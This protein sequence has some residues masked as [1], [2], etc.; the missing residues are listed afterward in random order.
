[1]R[2]PKLLLTALA[3]VFIFTALLSPAAVFARAE[4]ESSE[5]GLNFKITFTRGYTF[6]NP[7]TGAEADHLFTG[8]TPEPVTVNRGGSFVFPENTIKFYD[9]VF[10]CWKYS[11]KDKDGNTVTEKYSPG[12]I[13]ENV[14]GDM[15]VGAVWKRPVP[16]KLVINGFITFNKG[17][18]Y[19]EGE[20]IVPYR[21][22]C[23]KAIKLPDCPY[24]KDGYD[25]AGWVD[26]DGVLC[27]AGADYTV[28][29]AN[30][31]LTAVWNKNGESILTH[32]VTYSGGEGNV[33]GKG[34]AQFEMYKK[35]SFKVA[36]NTFVKEGYTF[37]YW[38]DASGAAR[39]PGDVLEVPQS[40][41]SQ[42]MLTAVWQQIT[43]YC[44]IIFA[45]S[46]DGAITPSGNAKVAKGGSYSFGLSPASGYRIKTVKVNGVDKP[47][48]SSYIIENI[49][50]NIAV[51]VVFE[52]IPRHAVIITCGEGGEAYADMNVAY[53]EEGGSVT[54]HIIPDEGYTVEAVYINGEAAVPSGGMLAINN[55]TEDI[56]VNVEFKSDENPRSNAFSAHDNSSEL[57]INPPTSVKYIYILAAFVALMTL[58]FIVFKI[59]R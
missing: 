58:G 43:E 39:Y 36:E 29:K 19:A 1:M 10:V 4:N 54:V 42:T 31:V 53:I 5:D 13:Y 50:E 45:V 11:Y 24:T 38:K 2:R 52:E 40:G 7:L 37:L 48:Q 34:P 33:T 3:C 9:Y 23:G 26:G 16:I 46:G 27:R 56:N 51:N 32:T 17:D 22:T 47:V 35:T 25:F 57:E 49:T 8:K 55:I 18:E 14:T 59:K 44:D 6:I 15:T 41:S 21:V 20:D 28:G 30:P 12:D